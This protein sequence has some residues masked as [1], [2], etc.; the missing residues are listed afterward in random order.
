MPTDL[1]ALVELLKDVVAFSLSSRDFIWMG[2]LGQDTRRE[3][4]RRSLRCAGGGLLVFRCEGSPS[5]LVV[6]GKGDRD[7]VS[8]N[9][10]RRSSICDP[11]LP[12]VSLTG[13]ACDRGLID[14]VLWS[15]RREEISG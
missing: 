8:K 9:S 7:Q 12:F 6:W 14:Y 11:V 10:G 15:D 2:F 4:V 13:R 1:E 3:Y 5:D